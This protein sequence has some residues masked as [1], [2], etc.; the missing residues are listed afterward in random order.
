MFEGIMQPMHLLVILFYRA[1]ILWPVKAR[2]T[3]EGTGRRYPALQECDEGGVGT[4][5]PGK[6]V[7]GTEVGNLRAE[8]PA[9]KVGCWPFVLA[10]G[11]LAVLLLLSL[12]RR[13][14]GDGQIPMS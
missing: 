10:A 13:N 6:Q 2:R 11:Q 5:I 12:R 1:F 14:V 8:R 4:C 3:G 9:L 7:A